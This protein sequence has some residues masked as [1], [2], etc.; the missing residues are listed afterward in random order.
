MITQE[1]LNAMMRNPGERKASPAP[2]PVCPQCGERYC[3]DGVDLCLE[4]QHKEQS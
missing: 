2:L 4:C 1:A 3:G